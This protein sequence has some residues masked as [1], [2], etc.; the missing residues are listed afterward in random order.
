MSVFHRRT[1]S[2]RVRSRQLAGE[3]HQCYCPWDCS[4]QGLVPFFPWVCLFVRRGS[5]WAQDGLVTVRF[6]P[7]R[8]WHLGDT[9]ASGASMPAP[10][11]DGWHSALGRGTVPRLLAQFI[12]VD[13]C[14][15]VSLHFC[16]VGTGASEG[17]RGHTRDESAGRRAKP[18]CGSACLLLH[19]CCS[20]PGVAQ[21]GYI[22]GCFGDASR[23]WA[24]WA[25]A[26][27]VSLATEHLCVVGAT[28]RSRQ[29]VGKAGVS[30]ES[31]SSHG[32]LG[33]QRALV[34]RSAPTVQ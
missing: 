33:A 1:S 31:V 19:Q 23:Q 7:G 30:R 20:D 6:G 11:A 17:V 27:R 22:S 26:V 18:V 4:G 9:F 28:M 3:A 29:L 5:Q 34:Y 24:H 10:H 13:E 14:V 2:H 12:F 15:S 8:F 25:H 32:S 21:I 16:V